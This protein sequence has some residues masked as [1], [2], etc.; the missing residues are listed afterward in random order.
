MI[1]DASLGKAV[2]TPRRYHNEVK[3]ETDLVA[4]IGNERYAGDADAKIGA[5][6]S[7][8]GSPG[9]ACIGFSLQGNLEG[10]RLGDI[11]DG[12]ITVDL[13]SV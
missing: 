4:D 8:G 1:S 5:L 12:Q 6:D 13:K 10:D 11:P 9:Q 7:G 2:L 3:F